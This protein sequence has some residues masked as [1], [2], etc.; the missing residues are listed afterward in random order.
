MLIRVVLGG[1]GFLSVQSLTLQV[2]S[3]GGLLGLVT[4]VGEVDNILLI[5]DQL[6]LVSSKLLLG[7][8]EGL[9]YD[10][11]PLIQV[12]EHSLKQFLDL[13]GL[14]K[15]SELRVQ[16]V[17]LLGGDGTAL[18]GMLLEQRDPGLDLLEGERVGLGGSGWLGLLSQHSQKAQDF[19]DKVTLELNVALLLGVF[20][21]HLVEALL[22]L[23]HGGRPLLIL[24]TGVGS[25]LL[26]LLD[27]LGLKTVLSLRIQ[28]R[29]Q[30]RLLGL[31]SCRVSG[32]PLSVLDLKLSEELVELGKNEV[33][34][35]TE[36]STLLQ[37]GLPRLLVHS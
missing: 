8:L 28:P 13:I 20:G 5:L 9:I 24:G 36:L 7:I 11:F 21:V 4:S 34:L 10:S 30:G 22:G 33:L 2:S 19:L 27:L 17:D 12:L 31:E 16:H 3:I 35:L 23:S 18:L 14:P 25:T 6:G 29:C 32:V 15:A 37:H 1:G 26:G